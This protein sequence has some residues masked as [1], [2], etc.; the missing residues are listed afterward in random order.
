MPARV[1]GRS[2]AA[3]RSPRS[4]SPGTLYG[5]PA[6]PFPAR[7]TPARRRG[8]AHR[9]YAPAAPSAA[10]SRPGAGEGRDTARGSKPRNQER[11]AARSR[12][13]RP[14]RREPRPRSGPGRP[15]AALRDEHAADR[16]GPPRLPMSCAGE[17]LRVTAISRA[18]IRG[19]ATAAA[20][21]TQSNGT[22]GPG[23]REPAERT[24]VQPRPSTGSQTAHSG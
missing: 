16:S 13:R 14:C 24:A 20:P 4:R 8:Q 23:S 19:T 21:C 9:G 5:Q 10:A 15:V 22:S 2:R 7:Q 6:A 12:Y 11:T 3:G 18:G 1:R 17:W